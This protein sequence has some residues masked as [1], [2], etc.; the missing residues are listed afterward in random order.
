LLLE[1][2]RSANSGSNHR[3]AA[4]V[5]PLL[6][7]A[8]LFSGCDVLKS[9]G[10]LPNDD[11]EPAPYVYVGKGEPVTGAKDLPSIKAKFGVDETIT[12]TAGVDAAFK[13]L[14]A[15]IKNGGLEKD[16]KL[17]VADR[18]IKPGNWIDLEGGLIVDAYVS[19]GGGFT[20]EMPTAGDTPAGLRLVVAGIN[21][22]QSSGSSGYTYP[23]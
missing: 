18:V 15:F 20:R 22:F 1:F 3:F 19:G 14:S 6:A 12:G 11:E 16:A 13:E 2:A 7:L 5:L 23:G 21:S 4:V 9:L 10:L 8:L 17:A